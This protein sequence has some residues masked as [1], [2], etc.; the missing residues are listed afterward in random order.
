MKQRAEIEKEAIKA[1]KIETF[2]MISSFSS[3]L[4][5]RYIKLQLQRKEK[6]GVATAKR[7]FLIYG[8]VTKINCGCEQCF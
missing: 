3:T 6:G 5:L 1:W 2:Q 7:V 4:L 8:V